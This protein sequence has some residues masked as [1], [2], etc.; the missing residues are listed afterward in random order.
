MEIHDEH[1]PPDAR[2]SDWLPE[3]GRRG[4]VVLMKDKRIRRNRLE[5][6]AL[7][8]AGV[9]A[10]VLTSGNL[11]G[12]EMAQVLAAHLV[13]MARILRGN[14][15]PFVAGVSRSGITVYRVGPL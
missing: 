7:L 2:D 10:F 4:W 3:V 8:S 13:R 12:P 9:R 6:D 14:P 1:F 11:T 15:G 5:R